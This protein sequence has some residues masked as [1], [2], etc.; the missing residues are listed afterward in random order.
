MTVVDLPDVIEARRY[1]I[2]RLH[3]ALA[4]DPLAPESRVGLRNLIDS[5]VVPYELMPYG[6]LSASC[7]L[8]WRL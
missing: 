5:I 8:S 3:A 4:S 7:L 6:R 2:E 1:N